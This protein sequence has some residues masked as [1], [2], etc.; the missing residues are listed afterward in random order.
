MNTLGWA[1]RSPEWLHF[2]LCSRMEGSGCGKSHQVGLP[3]VRLSPLVR[4]V[5]THTELSPIRGWM[6]SA[7]DT[8]SIFKLATVQRGRQKMG[9]VIKFWI[10]TN[11]TLEIFTGISQ[12]TSQLKMCRQHSKATWKF[13]DL[14]KR[15]SL[16]PFF[17]IQSGPGWKVFLWLKFSVQA[18][19]HQTRVIHSHCL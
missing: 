11:L 6:K 7:L 15:M 8:G 1:V 16:S 10:K 13:E 19:S 4:D 5:E 9:Q 18:L 14:D 2:Y 12:I 17:S 3:W